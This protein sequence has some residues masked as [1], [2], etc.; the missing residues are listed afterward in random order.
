MPLQVSGVPAGITVL[1]RA[2]NDMSH[3]YAAYTNMVTAASSYGI[4][5]FALLYGEGYTGQT[6]AQLSALLLKNMG[7]LPN[8]GLQTVLTDYL[9]SVGKANV[10]I[11]ALQL[12]QILSGLENAT[13]DLAIYGAAAA[14]WNLEVDTSHAY[15]QQPGQR[16]A[17]DHWPV[18]SGR[19]KLHTVADGRCRRPAGY[20]V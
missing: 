6:E 3:S 2:F 16:L 9:V 10:G 19:P 13:G 1:S 18:L 7:L 5:H 8:A 20:A 14:R 12:G 15:A 4:T 11:V 17:D